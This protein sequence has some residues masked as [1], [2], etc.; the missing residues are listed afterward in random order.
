MKI[1][2]NKPNRQK[3]RLGDIADY[4]DTYIKCADLITTNYIGTDNIKQNKQG[5]ENSQYTPN[6][7]FTTEYKKNDILIA[8]IRPYLKKIWFATNDGGSSTD[9]LTLR[10]NN[11]NYLPKFVY[12]NLFQDSFFD[13]AM[14]G[15]KGSKM[16]RG[17]K[18]QILNFEIPEFSLPTQTAIARTLSLLDDKIELNRKINAELEKVTRLIYDYWFVQNADPNWGKENLGKIAT[19]TAGQSPDGLS[20]NEQKNGIEFHQ[21]KTEFG[22]LLLNQSKKYTTQPQRFAEPLDILM[23]VRAPVG[24]LNVTDRR[25]C[26][27]RGLCSIRANKNYSQEFLWFA[28][29]SNQKNIVGNQGATFA[30][31]TSDEVKNIQIL[32]PDPAALQK[33]N[34]FVRPFFAQ[35]IKNRQE[36]ARLAELR[37]FL[38]PMLMNGQVIIKY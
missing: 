27:G 22:E 10:V 29:K 31:I 13:Y 15:T 21:G 23:S 25:I 28:L 33:F 1:I 38:L 19:I 3:V 32:I 14:K 20:Y 4:S 12:Y 2:I 34:S 37:D 26:I 18:N 8:N 5:K 35:I 30:A 16:P 17:D 7:G 11:E 36:S 24:A 6:T 9:V